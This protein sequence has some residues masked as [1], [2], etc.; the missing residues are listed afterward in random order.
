MLRKEND[1]LRSELSKERRE[2]EKFRKHTEIANIRCDM[3][4]QEM[5]RELKEY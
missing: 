2:T 4:Y 5:V 1:F 3:V